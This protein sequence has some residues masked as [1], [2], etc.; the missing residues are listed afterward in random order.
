MVICGTKLLKHPVYYLYNMI[1]LHNRCIQCIFACNL[2]I[3]TIHKLRYA[4][5]RID[6]C[7]H[8]LLTLNSKFGLHSAIL[9]LWKFLD[10]A[11]RLPVTYNF[12]PTEGIPPDGTPIKIIS[13][14]HT[15]T[16]VLL[17][18]LAS[19]GMILAAVCLVFNIVYRNHK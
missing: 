11:E 16:V 6:P 12:F 15:A 18:T 14:H 9:G 17:Y 5:L 8:K 3:C 10:Y 13:A 1:Y 7:L 4:T 19:L 2:G